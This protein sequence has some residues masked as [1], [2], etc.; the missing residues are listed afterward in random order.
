M[1]GVERPPP[2]SYLAQSSRKGPGCLSWNICK[3]KTME[4]VVGVGN[5]S[6]MM[7]GH[8]SNHQ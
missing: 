5:N 1:V 3:G 7:D 2:R 6:I 8:T 4:I